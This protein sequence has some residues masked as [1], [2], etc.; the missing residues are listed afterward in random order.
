MPKEPKQKD[1]K[2]K[3]GKAG[4]EKG[5]VSQVT[6]TMLGAGE[7]PHAQLSVE[8]GVLSLG[9]PKGEKGDRGP[10][11]TRRARS[12]GGRRPGAPG[13]RGAAGTSG[14]TGRARAARRSRNG[15]P[16]RWWACGRVIHLPLRGHGRQ[17]QVREARDDFRR[18]PGA[19]CV[20]AGELNLRSC[21]PSRV[22]SVRQC[23]G[24]LPGV[25][26]FRAQTRRGLPAPYAPG[27]EIRQ[28]G[29]APSPP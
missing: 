7:A 24:C 28:A 29:S 1:K 22:F 23:A 26:L 15:R 18:S 2:G 3:K 19:A 9:L 5:G 16:V 13:T 27:G 21:Q 10:G 25:F 6:V 14:G 12:Q 17:S 4:A 8:T 20:A 11:S